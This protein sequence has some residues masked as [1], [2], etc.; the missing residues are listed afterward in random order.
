MN[1]SFTPAFDEDS[2]ESEEDARR[3]FED[4][5]LLANMTKMVKRPA[6]RLPMNR[7]N[8]AQA[9]LDSAQYFRIGTLTT[10]A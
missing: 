1:S 2:D 9:P 3:Y 8:Q 5:T 10:N 7:P 6:F 4:R